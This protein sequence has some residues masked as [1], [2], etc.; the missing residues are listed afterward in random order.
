[1]EEPSFKFLRPEEFNKFDK[2]TLK[3]VENL[4]KFHIDSYNW[5]VDQGLRHAIKVSL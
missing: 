3:A 2:K 4:T 1:M 5:M